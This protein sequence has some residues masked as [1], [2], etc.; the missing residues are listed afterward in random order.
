MVLMALGMSDLSR[1]SSLVRE[2]QG[3]SLARH[4]YDYIPSQSRQKK[5]VLPNTE[6]E[7][8]YPQVLGFSLE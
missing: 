1:K 7:L 3:C 8:P 4:K 5:T 2:Q 6:A